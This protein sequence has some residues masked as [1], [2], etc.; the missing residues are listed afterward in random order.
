MDRNRWSNAPAMINLSGT[1][2][3]EKL[4]SGGQT[5]S[6]DR[7]R[8]EHRAVFVTSHKNRTPR[9][10]PSGFRY[11]S[12]EQNTQKSIVVSKEGGQPRA[13]CCARSGARSPE[14][15]QKREALLST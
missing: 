15:L 11:I 12:Q 13:S 3:F 4:M 6:E 7:Q 9:S 1:L 14:A 8:T 2:W 5:D 10:R